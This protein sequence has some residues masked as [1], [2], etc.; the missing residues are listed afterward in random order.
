MKK[1][2]RY[3]SFALA[4]I[5]CVLCIPF[6]A[7]VKTAAS[8]NVSMVFDD[9]SCMNGFS[10]TNNLLVQYSEGEEAVMMAVA[11]GD[12]FVLLNVEG[13]LDISADTY[14]YVVVTYRVPTTNTSA[15]NTTELFMCSG[16]IAV[17]TG[18]YS[19]QFARATGY[20]Y[21]SQIGHMTGER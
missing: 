9:S 14:K 16:N 13:S 4:V 21:H 15:A 11:G 18:D 8:P 1:T 3:L 12:P 2:T 6:G 7:A 10:Y 5:L 20:K 19:G 17:P